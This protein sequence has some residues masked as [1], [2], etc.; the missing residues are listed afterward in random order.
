MLLLIILTELPVTSCIYLR[1]TEF[2]AGVI[3]GPLF[4]RKINIQDQWRGGGHLQN[5]YCVCTCEGGRGHQ[6]LL[7]LITPLICLLSLNPMNNQRGL[8]LN[9]KPQ[10]LSFRNMGKLYPP[11]KPFTIITLRACVHA[12]QGSGLPVICR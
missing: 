8:M 4:C 2:A 9:P 10:S 3:K 7:L 12:Q 11:A 6:P 1:N 5:N